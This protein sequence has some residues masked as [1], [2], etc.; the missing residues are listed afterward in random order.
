MTNKTLKKISDNPNLIAFCNKI[1]SYNAIFENETTR[2][3]FLVSLI[4][5]DSLTDEQACDETI[6][7][8]NFILNHI[9]LFIIEDNIKKDIISKMKSAIKIAERDKKEFFI[10]RVEKMII[11]NGK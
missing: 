4:S 3:M 2:C 8:A 6:E 7:V 5:A 9:D 10:K 1:L 11:N